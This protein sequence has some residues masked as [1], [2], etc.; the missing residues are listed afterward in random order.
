[1]Q[2]TGDQLLAAAGFAADQHVDRQRCQIQHLP[3]QRLQASG[4]AQQRRIEFGAVV[5][6][7][8]QC[9][10]FQDQAALVQRPPQAAEQGLGAKGFFEKVVGAIA[11]RIDGHWHVTVAGQQDHR[12][13][14]I[15]SLH[16]G[17]QF[18]AGHARHAHVAENHPGEMLR[19]L[20][21]ALVGPAEQL[22][23]EPRQAQP[24]L[25]G[26]ADAAFVVDH[27]Y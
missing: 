24:L 8:M 6:L 3:A 16:L 21:Q 13:I 23:F 20:R 9:T 2:A 12:Q 4:Y 10:V 1:M 11:H 17:Q 18:K 25:D 5:C 19:Q 26:T 7:F 15:A 14:G 22:H 27:H